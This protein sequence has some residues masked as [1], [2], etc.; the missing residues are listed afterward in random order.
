MQNVF[1]RNVILC[2][3]TCA[4][5]VSSQRIHAS[6]ELQNGVTSSGIADNHEGVTRL[7]PVIQNLINNMHAATA[8]NSANTMVK[9]DGSGNFAAHVITASLSGNA[10][11]ATTA[12]NFSGSLSGDVAGGQSSTVV[13]T[14]GGQTAGDIADAVTIVG[15]ATSVNTPS[16]I[17]KRDEDGN[18]AVGA[19]NIQSLGSPF[20]PSLVS[21]TPLDDTLSA[22]NTILF[23][24]DNK[25]LIV[26]NNPSDG[27]NGSISVFSV[28]KNDGTLTPVD[29]SPFAFDDMLH[30]YDIAISS[31]G[32]FLAVSTPFNARI[33]ILNVN[34]TSGSLSAFSAFNNSSSR[35]ALAYS[36]NG[37]YLAAAGEYNHTIS[38]F[39]VDETNGALS[40]VSGSP[41]AAHSPHSIK[42]SP[43]GN[44]IAAADVSD[45]KVSIF[46]I[47]NNGSLS[48][49]SGSPYVVG[50]NSSPSPYYVAYS[51]NGKFLSVSNAGDY[52][53]DT[54]TV[55]AV[56]GQLSYLSRMFGYAPTELAYSADSQYLITS[57]LGQPPHGYIS[58]FSVNQDTGVMAA[59]D[60]YSAFELGLYPYRVSFSSNGNFLGIL[61][62][63]EQKI[64][65]VKGLNPQVFI[66]QHVNINGSLI[67][68]ATSNL[69]GVITLGQ[70]R[71]IHAAGTDNVFVGQG[72]GNLSVS[73]SNNVGIGANAGKSLLSGTNNIYISADAESTDESD[74]IRIGNGDTGACFMGGVYSGGVGDGAG[75]YVNADGQLGIAPSS[76]RYKENINDMTQALIEKLAALHPVSFTYK[77]DAATLTQ[78]GLIAEEVAKIMPELLVN[79][80]D[81]TPETVRYNTLISI[82]LYAYQQHDKRLQ[83]LE[84]QS[85]GLG[86]KP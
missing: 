37:K 41:F 74:T 36:P 17:V 55:N 32:R 72:A 15:S 50:A 86:Q 81:G 73:G 34:T 56:T 10:S 24:P 53:I 11:T 4:V 63:S 21:G 78:Y 27:S 58:I 1:L 85:A 18:F 8:S 33:V 3:L 14:V 83:A 68:P 22:P 52:S 47:D 26:S 23:T 6:D 75:V 64:A 57:A 51:P 29:G 13:A 69:G 12:T 82:L 25:F 40:E 49:V 30:P 79:N 28:N 19:L 35:Y 31:D 43:D 67:L 60:G 9:R 45:G 84:S 65:L 16:T 48:E 5:M 39:S 80:K 70:D 77:D 71:F 61:S 7:R 42:F 38:I 44:F 46:A 20:R 2:T 76:V 59:V 66:N 54:F 62:T